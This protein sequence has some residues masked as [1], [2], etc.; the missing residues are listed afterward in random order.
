MTKIS[1]ITFT[2]N[3]THRLKGLLEHVKDI[4]DEIIIVD[5]YSIDETVDIARSYGA[6]VYERKPWGYPEPDR[7]FALKQASYDWILYLDDDER[8]CSKLKKD[9]RSLVKSAD[10]NNIYAF[11][12]VRVNL[13]DSGRPI[14][15][16]FYPD[17]QIRIYR[18]DKVSYK[19]LIHEIPKVFGSI[20]TLPEDYYILHF[21]NKFWSK[22]MTQYAYIQS[23]QY[24]R[25]THPST[26]RRIL[27]HF[28]PLSSIIYYFYLLSAHS[29]R[30]RKPFNVEATLYTFRNVLYDSLV[31]TLIKLRDTKYEKIAKLLSEKG[32]IQI[33][34][35]D[36]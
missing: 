28:L 25:Y 3:S 6:K 23:I 11:S 33:M 24:Y 1:F 12:I 26:I 5:G 21:K 14:L 34:G 27:I 36:S 30:G 32:L 2:R 15:G 29:I 8:L 19:G 16:P 4:V 13:T 22:K 18:K 10:A 35:L 7:I 20:L 17:R 31:F 9:L